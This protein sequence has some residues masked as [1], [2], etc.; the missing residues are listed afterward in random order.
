[1][2]ASKKARRQL[3]MHDIYRRLGVDDSTR[4][5]AYRELFV[6]IKVKISFMILNVQLVFQCPWGMNFLLNK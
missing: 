4:Y 3:V 6:S 2:N 1:V 5:Y